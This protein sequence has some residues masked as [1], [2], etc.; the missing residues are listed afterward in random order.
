M[1]NVPLYAVT[2]AIATG[3]A[4]PT[5]GGLTDDKADSAVQYYQASLRS[6]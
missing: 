1:P 5:E 2:S 3:I 4:E 6:S